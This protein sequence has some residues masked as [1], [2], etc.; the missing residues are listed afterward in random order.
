MYDVPKYIGTYVH[1]ADGRRQKKPRRK[2]PR[3]EL[4]VEVWNDE[5]RKQAEPNGLCR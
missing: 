3:T 5:P 4:E 2:A 1:S